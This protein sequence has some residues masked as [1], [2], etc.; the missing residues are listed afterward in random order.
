MHV[1]CYGVHNYYCVHGTS[2]LCT[3][4][5]SGAFMHW[6]VPTSAAA[7]FLL[8]IFLWR[9]V[10]YTCHIKEWFVCILCRFIWT[11]PD[12]TEHKLR[13]AK[14]RRSSVNWAEEECCLLINGHTFGKQ[15][16]KCS[17]QWCSKPDS[18]SERWTNLW[19]IVFLVLLLSACD[20]F[21]FFSCSDIYFCMQILNTRQFP[22][23][24]LHTIA[25]YVMWC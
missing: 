23:S 2:C 3:L 19:W 13:C 15:P 17:G 8:G 10:I 11:V 25:M 1:P 24:V 14:R 4:S 7:R 6:A 5:A 21:D 16:A 18:I 12:C 9:P 20:I 22:F